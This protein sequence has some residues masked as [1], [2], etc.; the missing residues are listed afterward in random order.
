MQTLSP[1]TLLHNNT[2]RIER[3]L[4]QGGFGITYL[5]VDT[6]MQRK[7]AGLSV[8]WAFQNMGALKPEDFGTYVNKLDVS[9]TGGVS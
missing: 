1:G 5:A 8:L 9:T 4:G 2:Y 3:V 6:T 7:V